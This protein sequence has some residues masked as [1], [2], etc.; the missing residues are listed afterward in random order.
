[1]DVWATYRIESEAGRHRLVRD[2][3]VQIYPPDFVPGGGK[4]LSIQQT[5][6]RGILQKRFNKVFDEVI[7]IKPLDLPGELAAAGPLPME[8]FEARKDGWLAAGWRKADPVVYESVVD[9]SVVHERVIQGEMIPGEV[10]I[11]ERIL[12]TEPVVH[13]GVTFESAAEGGTNPGS[14]VLSQP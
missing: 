7:E 8:Q 4:K 12:S 1:M 13:G 5:S 11:E 3:D 2:G 10:I 6:L 14:L 9:G